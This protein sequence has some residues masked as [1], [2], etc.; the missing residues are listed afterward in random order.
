MRLIGASGNIQRNGGGNSGGKNKGQDKLYCIKEKGKIPMKIEIKTNVSNF[1][2][3]ERNNPAL[4]VLSFG[5]TPA[6][7]YRNAV[8]LHKET[9]RDMLSGGYGADIIRY[10]ATKKTYRV[11]VFKW[12]SENGAIIRAAAGNK[13]EKRI[14]DFIA[15][16]D[17]FFDVIAEMGYAIS[18]T[19]FT[20]LFNSKLVQIEKPDSGYCGYDGVAFELSIKAILTPHSRWRNRATPQ[21]KIDVSK[22][23]NADEK[24]VLL[25]YGLID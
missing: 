9:V 12:T 24:R 15:E 18:E 13:S 23:W 19:E 2:E 6:E 17:S 16:H 1:T 20:E 7:L 10:D 25:E 21:G 11:R 8:I 3:N 14:R 22:T 5:Y 4:T